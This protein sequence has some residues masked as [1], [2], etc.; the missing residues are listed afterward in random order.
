MKDLL[1]NAA[2]DRPHATLSVMA[3]FV[4]AGIAARFAIPIESEPNIEVP[5]FMVSVAH[6]GISPEDAERLLLK[7]LESE[8]RIIDGMDEVRALA[9]EG[10]ARVLVEFDASHDLDDALAEVREAVDRAKPEFPTT[11][12]EPVVLEQSA[13]DF[14]ILQVNLVGGREAGVSERVVFGLAQDLR[15]AIETLPRSS[16]RSCRD[17]GRNSSRS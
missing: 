15:D 9:S 13:S 6:E 2:I 3:L 8:L 5:F 10:S 17:I 12:D 14:P 16:P 7:P 4:L 11:A 1:I